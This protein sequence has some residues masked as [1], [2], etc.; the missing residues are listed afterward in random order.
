MMN[1]YAIETEV[2]GKLTTLLSL[3]DKET[4]GRV[5]NDKAIVG[6]LKS[7]DAAFMPNN[8]IY[9]PTFVKFFHQTMLL[10]AEFTSANAPIGK[11]GFMYLIDERC[12]SPEK[13]EQRDIIGSFEVKA[14][15][16]LKDTYVPNNSYEFISSDGLFQLPNQI[17]KVLF[18]AL[19]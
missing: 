3:L 16:M 18:L 2:Q 5:K 13:P 19:T 12:S 17:E 11:S 8:I 9:N 6:I 1:L 10:F 4:L 7:K 14:G 15:I